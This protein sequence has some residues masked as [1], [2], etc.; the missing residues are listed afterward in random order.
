MWDPATY[1]SFSDHR[2]RPARELMARV[3]AETARRAVDLGC[4]AG[5]LTHLLTDRWP[6]AELEALDASPEMVEAARRRGVPA[7]VRDVRAWWPAPDTD[8]VLCNA[9][10]QWVPEHADLL[11]RWIP[12]LPAGAWFAFQVPGNFDAPSHRAIRELAASPRWGDR[13]RELAFRE[14]AVLTPQRYADALADLGAEV[15]AWE[16]TY[17]QPLR[18]DDP[19]L[20]WVTGTALRPVRAALDDSE[21]EQFRAD[22]APRLAEAYPRRPDGVTWFPFRRLFVV[23]RAG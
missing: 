14:D 23:A 18:G 3:G 16:T 13:L 19:V 5:N 15:D 22:L 11:A 4:G 7:Q 8:V 1:L 12:E 21:W 20:E 17:V 9:V 2:G 6:T 10:L